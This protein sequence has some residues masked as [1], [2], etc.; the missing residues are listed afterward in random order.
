MILCAHIML[1]KKRKELIV[2]GLWCC[3]GSNL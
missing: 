2:N 3:I 1:R